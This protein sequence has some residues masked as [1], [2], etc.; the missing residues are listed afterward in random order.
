MVSSLYPSFEA[1]TFLAVM[2]LSA[3]TV[4]A[5]EILSV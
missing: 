5:E 1:T 4:V 2:A 3:I